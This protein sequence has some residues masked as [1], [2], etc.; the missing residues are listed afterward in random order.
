MLSDYAAV[1]SGFHRHYLGCKKIVAC[2]SMDHETFQ[3]RLMGK[4]EMLIIITGNACRSMQ[5]RGLRASTGAAQQI[6]CAQHLR[7]H[8]P[9]HPLS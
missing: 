6:S 7:L 3:L 5:R 9:S 4:A 1:I 8:S 2:V